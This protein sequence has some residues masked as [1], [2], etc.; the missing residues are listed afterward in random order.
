MT[1]EISGKTDIDNLPKSNIELEIKEK[2]NV[3]LNNIFK[4][5]NDVG[6]KGQLDLPSRDIPMS[7]SNITMDREFY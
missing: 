2:G 4:Q 7:Q 3:D 6:T 5:I 1:E